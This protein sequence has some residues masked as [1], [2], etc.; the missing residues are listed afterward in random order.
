[1]F[2]VL[3]LF[4]FSLVVN[5]YLLLGL[6]HSEALS[7]NPRYMLLKNLIVSDLLQT[8]TFAPS[9]LY[10][11]L[12]RTTLSFSLGCLSSFFT[13]ALAIITSLLTVAS[14]ALERFIYT[15]HGIHYLAF[16][17]KIRMYY[18]VTLIWLLG[19]A[20][21]G[22]STILVMVEKVKFEGIVA[23]LVC[24]PEVL[25]AQM[26]EPMYFDLFNK[27]FIGT[28]LI[29]C[30][31]MFLF[32]YGRMYQEA[33]QVQQ[34]FQQDNVRARC[35]IS[36]YFAIFLLQLFPNVITFITLCGKDVNNQMY[37]YVLILVPSCVNPLAYGIRNVE[38]RQALKRLCGLK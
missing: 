26:K 30:L 36:F 16:M 19:V 27:V 32:S 18:F 12:S 15:C 3:A 10:C 38:V 35:T 6:E 1:M 23:G 2:L 20:G 34:P 14:M 17:T 22:T 29:L 24:E 4:I 33:C 9:T 21:A 31:L 5:V 37:M 25:Q 13:G 7:W 11:L 8:L 28:L